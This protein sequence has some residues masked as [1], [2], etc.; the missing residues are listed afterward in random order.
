M[1]KIGLFGGTFNPIHRGHLRVA[2]QV[3]QGFGLDQVILIPAALPPHKMPGGVVAAENRLQMILLAIEDTAG[4]GV[5]DVELKRTGL[6]YTIDTV[7]HFKN[8][9][10]GNAQIF[11]I[12]GLDAFLEI[13]SWKSYD[14]LLEKIAF[15]I[16]N[17]PLGGHSDNAGWKRLE[18]YLISQI[19]PDYTFHASQSCYRRPGCP[20]IHVCQIDALDVSSTRIREMIKKDRPID[21]LVPPKVAQYIISKGLYL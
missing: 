11:L 17:R 10:A 16:V 9:L 18:K 21:R 3:K 8:T 2:K 1:K 6:S 4:L 5:S 12:M 15:I 20:P 14:K 7:Q 13:D 19:S